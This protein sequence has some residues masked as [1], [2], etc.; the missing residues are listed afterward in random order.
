M[1]IKKFES[2]KENIQSNEHLIE[3]K[4]QLDIEFD[5]TYKYSHGKVRRF[6]NFLLKTFAF[7][8]FKLIHFFTFNLKVRGKENLK[9]LRKDKQNFIITCNHCMF[10]DSA[11]NIITC[12][13]NTLFIPTVENTLRMPFLRHIIASFNVIPIPSKPKSLVCFKNAVNNLL[14]SGDSL[15]LFPEG[16][17][18]PYYPELREFKTGAFRFAV[19]NNVPILPGCITFRERRGIWKILGKKPLVTYTFLP[20]IYPNKN[21]QKKLAINSLKQSTFDSM[22]DFLNKHPWHNPEYDHIKIINDENSLTTE[23]VKND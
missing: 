5:E 13:K 3:L 12:Y 15:L 2:Q 19:D 7:P 4:H 6:F 1:E 23:G 11:I 18:W 16:A 9:K 22:N 8:I 17:L 20:P 10:L 14:K 21:L